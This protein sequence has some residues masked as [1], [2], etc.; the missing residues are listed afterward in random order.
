MSK[1]CERTIFLSDCQSF[2]AS[3]EKATH[4]GLDNL[5]VVVA[6]DPAR[7]SGIILA[8]C[9]IAKSFGI[10]T[11]QRLGEALQL[12]PNAIVMRPHMQ[13]YIDVSLAITDI[14]EKYTDLVEVFSIDEQFLDV[15]G[16]LNHFGCTPDELAVMIQQK[17]AASMNVRIRVGIG[18]TK[19]LAK[20]ATDNFAKKNSSGIFTLGKD[21]VERFLWPLS[22]DKMYGVGSRM[23][24][25][26]V[27]LGMTT[28]GHVA[29]TP[30]A[31]LKQ[32][33]RARFGKQ[34]DIQAEV[35]W[36]TANGLDDSPVTPG[37]FDIAP[38]SIGH[39][40][41][42]PRDYLTVE[43]VD[44]VLLELTE[45]VCRD[46]RAKGF[47]S[48]TVH[49]FCMCS[50]YDSPTGF[51]QQR[52]MPLN[53]NH[54]L[55]VYD[56]VREIFRRNWN[57]LPVRKVGV[58]LGTLAEEDVT[59][60]DLFEDVTKLRELDRVVDGIKERFGNTAIIRASSL[61]KAGLATD[62]AGKIGGHYR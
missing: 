31:I 9:P 48:G 38:K 10:T 14:Y 13:R 44:V 16:S 1:K 11:A 3:V 2:Y 29:K 37:T 26:F 45:E 50:P 19:I 60:L 62:R 7:R 42:L 20:Q 61:M 28:I 57:G 47:T 32:K 15:T 58:T 25:H 55:K 53:T 35:M 51:S 41:T 49:V 34:S 40:M 30:L 56:S 54:T 59:Q 27:V 18:P 17:V 24:R 5:P 46:A 33:F 43:E 22:I 12:C 8:A 23:T 36:R 52:K 21:D 39:A 4:P 6:G